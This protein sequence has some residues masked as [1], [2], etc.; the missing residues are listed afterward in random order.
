MNEKTKN[1]LIGVLIV[2]I[3]AMTVAY[4]AL[5]Q[6]L[7]ING[8]AR[9][10]GKDDSW[11]IHFKH[12]TNVANEVVTHEYASAASNSISLTETN[13]V[14]T[15][16]A[17]TLKAPGDYVEFKFNVINE[18]D[19]TGYINTLNNI[20]MGTP[21]YGAGEDLTPEEKT[22]FESAIT[23]T[24]T[25]ADTTALALN[26]SIAKNEEKELLLV[27]KYN[28][29]A[30]TQKLPK[31]AVTFNN[32]TAS[33][34]YGQDTVSGGGGQVTPAVTY[35][36]GDLVYFDP[37]SEETCD[38]TTFNLNS[39]ISHQTNCFKW[40]VIGINGNDLTLQMDHN[41]VNTMAW[42]TS[43]STNAGPSSVFG[44]LQYFTGGWTRVDPL[45]YQYDTSSVTNGY[46]LLSCVN[47][48]CT[49]SK[50]GASFGD[51]SSPIRARIITGDEIKAIAMLSNLEDKTNI[52]NWTK[53]V[54]YADMDY[55]TYDIIS[56]GSDIAWLIENTYANEEGGGTDN[57]YDST[58]AGYWTLNPFD[59]RS[60]LAWR[61]DSGGKLSYYNVDSGNTY[62]IRPVIEVS[63]SLVTK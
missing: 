7:N 36:I 4:A 50:V 41:I 24:L 58:N 49:T 39:V 48:V 38:S 8:S 56:P 2:G 29:T 16:P 14:A 57:L 43:P 11:N 25:Y 60:N 15:M 26:D 46:G 35:A 51:A 1:I 20:S 45:N 21:I 27:I 6:T 30:A 53:N 54:R 12:I 5:S 13:T 63:D 34:T 23:A 17:V 37:V 3:V 55:S 62:G 40:R 18:G 22:A 32:I 44:A 52:S 31:V 61:L 19:I 59:D 28:N 47:G 10:Q 42:T 9:V 33:I